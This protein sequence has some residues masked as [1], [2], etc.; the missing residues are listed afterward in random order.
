MFYQ[1]YGEEAKGSLVAE[2]CGQEAVD[3]QAITALGI[4]LIF[5]LLDILQ[6]PFLG[7]D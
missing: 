3:F 1:A 4:N 5:L 2:S 6:K 7:L